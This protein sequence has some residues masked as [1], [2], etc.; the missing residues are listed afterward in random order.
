MPRVKRG[1]KRR[2]RRTR[3]LKKAE[4]FYAARSRLIRKASEAVDR[5]LA[6]S[7]VGRKRK[8]RDYRSLWQMRI[9]AAAKLSGT[10]Y[11][12]LMG[13]LRKKRVALDRK[14]LAMMAVDHPSDFKAIVTF[15]QGA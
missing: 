10:S 6:T 14:M 9:A 4:G 3:L 15:S 2:H 5:A 8:K 1:F 12:R 7:Y 13:N 11:S